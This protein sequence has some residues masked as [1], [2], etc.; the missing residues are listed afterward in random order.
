LLRLGGEEG[1]A[2]DALRPEELKYVPAAARAIGM[3]LCS[4]DYWLTDDHPQGIMINEVNGFPGLPPRE[5]LPFARAVVQMIGKRHA[6]KPGEPNP[7]Q[8]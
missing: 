4:I 3:T 1:I 8:P 6:A 5:A 7:A 2:W